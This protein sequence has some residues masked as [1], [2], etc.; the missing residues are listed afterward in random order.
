M[1]MTPVEI[2]ENLCS[3][4][5]RNPNYIECGREPRVDCRCD[6]CFYGRDLLARE[7]LDREKTSVEE[8]TS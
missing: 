2:T 3:Y 5:P 4:D 6:N 7:I 1:V 8:M